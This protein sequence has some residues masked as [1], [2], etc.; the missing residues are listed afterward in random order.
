MGVDGS[1]RLLGMLG[2]VAGFLVAVLI[3][4]A[5]I[6]LYRALVR[7]QARQAMLES[8]LE[9]EQT[10]SS[11]R[12]EFIANASHELR[13]PLTSISGLAM[14][15]EEDPSIATDPTLSEMVGLIVGEAADLRRMVEDMLTT[16]RL[17]VGAL[18]FEF[19]DIDAPRILSEVVESMRT[20]S[21]NV[22]VSCEEGVVRGDPTRLRQILRNLLSNAHKYGGPNVSVQGRVEDR[23]YVWE[24]ID[25]GDGVPEGI[26]NELFERFVHR[27]KDTSTRGSVGLGLSIVRSL[28][29]AMGGHVS[30]RRQSGSTVF[31]IRMPLS[32]S[33]DAMGAAPDGVLVSS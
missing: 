5:V 2:T 19:E 17:D 30:Y 6:L 12:E 13:T 25:D 20:I 27:G 33:V 11:A 3:P 29:D 31:S 4:A 15:L 7:R 10:L 21:A 32:E 18:S 14:V 23:T 8:R 1:D 24:V 28:A 22:I 16:A 26:E 9:A